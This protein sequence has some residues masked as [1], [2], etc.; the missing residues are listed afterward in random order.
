MSSLVLRA[1]VG[2]CSGP[3]LPQAIEL[4]IA[5]ILVLFD[6]D[7]RPGIEPTCHILQEC[8]RMLETARVNRSLH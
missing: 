5:N 4:I 3:R 8:V 7:V 1:P 2:D 6:D